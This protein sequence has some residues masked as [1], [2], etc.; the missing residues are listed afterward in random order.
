VSIGQLPAARLLASIESPDV[1]AAEIEAIIA[2]EPGLAY[3]LLRLANSSSVG[4]PR[5]VT[6]L[7]EALLLLGRR[8]TK[9]LALVAMIH[10]VEGKTSELATTAMVR[11]KMCEQL[12]V[13]VA[14]DSAPAAFLVGLLSVLDAVFDAPL[15][16]LITQLALSDEIVGALV[17]HQGQL[18]ELLDVAVGYERGEQSLPRTADLTAEATLAAYVTAVPWADKTMAELANFDDRPRRLEGARARGGR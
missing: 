10:G 11:A 6:S 17:A 7:R 16:G 13:Q 15:A 1:S 9:N 12:A 2:C 3:R 8:T 4:V 5:P 14:P 18:G